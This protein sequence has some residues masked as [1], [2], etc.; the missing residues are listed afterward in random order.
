MLKNKKLIFVGP[1]G[2]PMKEYLDRYDYVIRTNNFFSIEPSEISCNRCDILVTNSMY[3]S[4]FHKIV[5][6]NLWKIKYLF[7]P[8]SRLDFIKEKIHEKFH[9]KII[10]MSY[11]KNNH[12]FIVDGYPLLLSRLLYFILEKYPNEYPEK[13]FV[14][15]IDFYDSKNI[16]Q[17]WFKGYEVPGDKQ[18]KLLTI[19]KSKHKPESNKIFFK[20][21]YN[22]YKWISCDAKILNIINKCKIN[23]TDLLVNNKN[24]TK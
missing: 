9:H 7:V 12:D 4:R 10:P 1:I 19:G 5:V 17:F 14:T 6:N 23:D 8:M 3:I 2:N 21:L 18:S 20:Y 15:G 16:K 24:N 13:F 11:N 22:K